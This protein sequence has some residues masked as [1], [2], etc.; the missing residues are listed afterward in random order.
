MMEKKKV[1]FVCTNNSVRSQMAEAILNSFYGERYE[2]FS[3]GSA[4]TEVNPMT[5]SVLKEIGMDMSNHYSK[6]LDLYKDDK[7]DY[8]ITVCDRAKESCPYFP[9]GKK[10]LHKS[11]RDPSL[12]KGSPEDI[13]E[14]F[15]KLRDEIK[16]WIEKKFK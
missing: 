2:A 5:T 14:G 1:L 10:R 15:R 16:K 6:G 3:A 13:V 12:L 11:F 8:V 4:P 7:F 9:N